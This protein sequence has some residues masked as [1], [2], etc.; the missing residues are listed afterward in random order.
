MKAK[1]LEVKQMNFNRIFKMQYKMLVLSWAK[2]PAESFAR[3]QWEMR[4]PTWTYTGIR[5]SVI[6]KATVGTVALW[7]ASI[8]T[9]PRCLNNKQTNGPTRSLLK[10]QLWF[11]VGLL[12]YGKN[13][14]HEYFGKNLNHD[15]STNYFWVWKHDVFIQH[16]S[17][18]KHFVTEHFE[19]LP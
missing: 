19:I 1:R 8:F 4:R 11:H 14:N 15:S 3:K 13:H 9:L 12:D 6:H 5:L 10:A 17:P 18:K 16:V 7:P 2:W